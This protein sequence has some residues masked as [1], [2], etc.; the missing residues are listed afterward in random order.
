MDENI[1]IGKFGQDDTSGIESERGE[2]SVPQRIDDLEKRAKEVSK[3]FQGLE[4]NFKRLENRLNNTSV[5]MMWMT[6]II[7][8]VF[9]I[10]GILIAL[11]YF[12]N[13]YDRYNG[14]SDNF[15][16]SI[17]EV[18]N[19][20]NFIELKVQEIE[21]K[22]IILNDLIKNNNISNSEKEELKNEVNK[23]QSVVD[24]LKIK[25]YFSNKCFLN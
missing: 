18:K 13:N 11:D 8:G 14:L 25:G 23:L 20:N 4:D 7:V 21:R 1:Q 19:K 22:G 16:S 17:N 5:F 15:N 10:T 2:I 9:F 3:S 24:C 6:G 12:K